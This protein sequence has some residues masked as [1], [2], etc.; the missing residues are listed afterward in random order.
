MNKAA[1]I[2]GRLQTIPHPDPDLTEASWCEVQ[3]CK[4]IRVGSRTLVISQPSSS[5]LVYLL[6]VLTIAVGAY[7][8]NTLQGEQSRWWWGVSLLFWG[9][10]ALLAGTSYQAF[11]F[12]IKCSGRAVCR[13]T[14]WWEVG[15]L[16]LQSLSMHAMLVAVAHSTVDGPVR[17]GLVMYAAVSGAIYLIVVLIGAFVPVKPLITFEF[18]VLFFVPILLMFFVLNG[19]RFYNSR[20][21]I[22]LA[23]LLTWLSLVLICLLYFLYSKKGWTERLWRK[24][25]GFWFSDNDLLHVCLIGWMLWILFFVADQIRDHPV[26]T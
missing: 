24:G 13:W 2:F 3:P 26:L 21:A 10:A 16:I 11:G 1:S 4:R 6:G 25:T 22:D 9:V 23:L 15:Y 18:M 17:D 5:V 8:L 19:W 12:H 7:F 14:S 20:E